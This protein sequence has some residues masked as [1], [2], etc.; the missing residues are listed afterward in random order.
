MID[1]GERRSLRGS[2][3]STT[4]SGSVNVLR[5]T[6]VGTKNAFPKTK[7]GYNRDGRS[8]CRQMVIAL[9]VTVDGLPLA[10]EVLAGNTTDKTTLRDFLAKI[11]RMYGKARR[12]W[13]GYPLA[14]AGDSHEL[15]KPP[16]RVML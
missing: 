7:H 13:V 16:C 15:S 14:G 5:R 3:G 4:C 1:I 2:G 12:V 8:D 9:I 10:Y 11:E 6:S